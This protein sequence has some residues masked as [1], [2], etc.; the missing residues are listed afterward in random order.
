ML[1]LFE[2]CRSGRP[3]GD[4]PD[5]PVGASQEARSERLAWE[6]KIDE[7]IG[8][9]TW[10]TF[11]PASEQH[12]I[13]EASMLVDLY[14]NNR[15]EDAG[16][17]RRSGILTAGTLIRDIDAKQV[18]FIIRTYAVACLVWP[19]KEVDKGVWI[20]DPLVKR[21][22]F[23]SFFDLTILREI[24]LQFASPLRLRIETVSYLYLSHSLRLFHG[25]VLSLVSLQN[26]R[27]IS[28]VE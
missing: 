17:S 25:L 8:P 26:M 20:P 24:P 19:A 16:H 10:T 5:N 18:M 23:R 27:S 9:M 13:S 22:E 2:K 28:H 6:K 15:W 7:V 4:E 21:L 11:T 14:K 3:F 12:L 1:R